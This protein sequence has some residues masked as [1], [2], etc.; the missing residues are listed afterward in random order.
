MLDLLVSIAV[1]AILIL[2]LLPS[3][4]GAQE[5]ARRVRCANNVRQVGIAMQAYCFDHH[6][7]LPPLVLGQTTDGRINT[8]GRNPASSDMSDWTNDSMYAR[9]EGASPSSREDRTWQGLG[10]LVEDD[11]LSHNGVLYCP[12]HHGSHHYSEYASRWLRDEGSIATNYQYRIPTESRYL[13]DLDPRTSLLSDGLATRSDYNHIKG[14]NFLRADI[15]V[16]W[17]TDIDSSLYES[18]PESTNSPD[19]T[20]QGVRPGWDIFDEVVAERMH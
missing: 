10:I 8:N 19:A 5:T 20:P 11:Y 18:L 14:N 6:D 7:H 9:L 1:M 15:G 13:S 12:S 2:I 3:M 4:R 16:F 17:F